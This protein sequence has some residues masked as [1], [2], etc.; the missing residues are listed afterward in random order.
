MWIR[1]RI[2]GQVGFFI[3]QFDKLYT[4]YAGM[5]DYEGSRED[6]T[7][8]KMYTCAVTTRKNAIL[9]MDMSDLTG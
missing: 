7:E 3:R 8:K 2:R 9:L 5:L 1:T 6:A 4:P